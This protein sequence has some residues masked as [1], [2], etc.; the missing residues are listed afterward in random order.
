MTDEELGKIAYEG[1]CSATGGQ[2][3][4]TGEKLPSWDEQR[5]DIKRAWIS[6]AHAVLSATEVYM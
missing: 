5:E 6:S 2:S 3:A 1:Y 4:I